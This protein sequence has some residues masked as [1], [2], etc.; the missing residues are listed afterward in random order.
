MRND[1]VQVSCDLRLGNELRMVA[2]RDR[3]Q[4]PRFGLHLDSEPGRRSTGGEIVVAFDQ[5]E[6]ERCVPCAPCLQHSQRRIRMR[7]AR[8]KEIAEEHDGR[9]LQP[10]N[11]ARQARKRF[12][13]RSLRD[14]HAPGAECGRLAEVRVG[15]DKPAA[16]APERSAIG[17]QRSL[18]AA[19]FEQALTAHSSVTVNPRARSISTSP[20]GPTRWSEPTANRWILPSASIDSIRR[21][22]RG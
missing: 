1:R 14:R 17:Q 6:V 2:E 9:R 5:H 18:T 11:Q 8:V 21:T 19:Q 20:C 12:T 4:A 3:A 16:I 15:D 7:L 22:I 10:F 13:R